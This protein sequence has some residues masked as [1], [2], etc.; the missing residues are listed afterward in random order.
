MLIRVLSLFTSDYRQWEPH[1]AGSR[2]WIPGTSCRPSSVLPLSYSIY[3]VSHQW[4]SAM[5]APHSWISCMDSWHILP[6]LVCPSFIIQYIYSISPVII[7]NESPTQLDLV[8]GFLA[9]PADPRLSFLYHTV[10]IQYLTSDYRQW[11]PHT[12]GSRAWIPG[13]SCRPSSVLPLSYSIYTVS[14]Q[15]LSAMRAPHSWI[16]CMDSWHILPTLVWPSFITYRSISDRIGSSFRF[17]KLGR[18]L[19]TLNAMPA[20]C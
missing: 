8:H 7:G 20:F 17:T 18:W 14:H 13:T 11:E 2:A 19:S 4:L 10:Y 3:T 1:T 5:R 12:A 15:W 9:H 6:T 16:S